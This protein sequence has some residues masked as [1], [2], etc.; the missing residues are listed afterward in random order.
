[1]ARSQNR[2]FRL[3]ICLLV[4]PTTN[5]IRSGVRAEFRSAGD[6]RT[7]SQLTM[8]VNGLRDEKKDNFLSPVA[9]SEKSEEDSGPKKSKEVSEKVGKQMLILKQKLQAEMNSK[10]LLEEKLEMA[11]STIATQKKEILL[12]QRQ[13]QSGV[14]E[15]SGRRL[16]GS[17]RE[18]NLLKPKSSGL[19]RAEK[20][21]QE[22]DDSHLQNSLSRLCAERDEL[23]NCVRKQGKLIEILKRQKLHLEAFILADMSENELGKYFDLARI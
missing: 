15:L 16:E 3:I 20:S 23:L 9:L 14:S 13:L 6:I 21:S 8:A 17:L 22:D 18:A 5:F 4:T 11:K 19:G 10:K 7:K 1:M 12:L 2:T